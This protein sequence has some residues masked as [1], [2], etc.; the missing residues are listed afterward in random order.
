MQKGEDVAGTNTKKPDGT[1]HMYGSRA[2]PYS[3]DVKWATRI[4]VDGEYVHAAPWN[5]KNLGVQSTSNGCTNLATTDAQ[6]FYN[7]SLLGDLVIYNTT[8]DTM[9]SWDGYGW[10]NVP[11]PTWQ[12]GGLLLNH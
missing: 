5:V 9:P 1:V 7:W 12:G 6:W 8:G 4:T 2:D 10:W 3:L 11:W